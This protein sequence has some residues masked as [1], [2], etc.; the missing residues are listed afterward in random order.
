VSNAANGLLPALDLSGSVTLD[1]DPEH[2][3]STSYNTERATWRGAASLE[4][5]LDRK[6]ERNAYRASL[7]TWQQAC[8]AYD[9]GRDQVI[10]NVRQAVRRIRQAQLNVRNAELGQTLAM[11]RRE[12][13]EYR[14][15]RGLISNRDVV[16]AEL[17]LLDAR[18]RLAI[19][20]SGLRSTILEFRRDT[21][22]LRIDDC[23]RWLDL[24]GS[25]K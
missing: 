18:D 25:D 15:Q 24:S 11:E 23:G 13:A 19:A 10:A 1:T 7:I 6:E 17:A 14:V 12:A 20:R 21:G 3:N 22:T 16:E 9:L 4:I 5:P 2:F 8:R